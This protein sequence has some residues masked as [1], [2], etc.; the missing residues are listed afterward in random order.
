MAGI[1]YGRKPEAGGGLSP[2][3]HLFRGVRAG[4]RRARPSPDP[5]RP[6]R[7]AADLAV[8]LKVAAK[9]SAPPASSPRW[10]HPAA[11]VGAGATRFRVTVPPTHLRVGEGNAVPESPT[12]SCPG[13]PQAWGWGV[14]H[15]CISICVNAVCHTYASTRGVVH[16][17][18]LPLWSQAPLRAPVPLAL[19]STRQGLKIPAPG[20]PGPPRRVPAGQQGTR[21]FGHLCQSAAGPSPA[22]RQHG[23]GLEQTGR[24]HLVVNGS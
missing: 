24:H 5:G 16:R 15:A 7:P 18:P 11:T 22:P 8:R 12:M 2:H 9:A 1:F 6:S 13:L 17:G 14:A 23:D 4:L 3:T 19:S 20:S 21:T 10:H